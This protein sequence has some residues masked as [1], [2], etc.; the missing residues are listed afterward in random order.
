MKQPLI[1]DINRA[2]TVDGPGVRTTVFFKG[3]DL[4]CFWCHNPESKIA[5]A[6]L[7]IFSD[8][9]VGCGS[10]AS[11]CGADREECI[12]CGRCVQLCPVSARKLYGTKYSPE[13]LLKIIA[14]DKLY[15][16]ATGGGVTFSGG[17]CMLYPE[18]VALLAKL[19]QESDISVAIDT[20]GYVPYESFEKVLPYVDIFL[21]DIK[22]IDGELHRKG[23]G[24]D[25]ELILENLER[26]IKEGKRIIIRTPQIPD[27]NDGEE[28]ERIK[29][30][31]IEKGL[32]HEILSY[33][34]FGEDKKK[35]LL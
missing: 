8:K 6:Q 10:C 9:C 22:C 27:F 3:C 29:A 34:E 16:D 35:A 17:E 31:C 21:Y 1:F 28:L 15:Y 19:C 24:K 18:F 14:A 20:A 33:H 11:V 32:E 2:S 30:F 4:D 5:R 26:L 23:T 25:N 7:A 12:S 13:E